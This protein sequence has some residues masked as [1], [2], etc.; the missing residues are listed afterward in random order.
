MDYGVP[1]DR[2]RL[3]VVGVRKDLSQDKREFI[4][5]AA[6][7]K[8]IGAR[9]LEWP[10]QHRFGGKPP[11][12]T[13]LPEELMVHTA[14]G[15][16]NGIEHLANGQEWFM[17]YSKKFK[18]VPEG[19]VS[20]KSFKRLHR[21]RFSPTAWYGHNEVHLHPSE[22]RRLSV[23]EALRLQTVPDEYVLPADFQLSAK[24]KLICNGVP[25]MLANRLAQSVRS[26]ISWL[27]S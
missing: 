3:F 19:D 9:D 1:Q 5:P 23:R 7:K 16:D 12:P 11:K 6:E 4:W 21:F 27:V 20:A 25:V 8:F 14:L 22:P 18:E 26:H 13:G 2:E 17:P 10:R 15:G 24:F